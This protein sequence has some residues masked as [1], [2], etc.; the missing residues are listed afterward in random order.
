MLP[1]MVY[2][3]AIT[4]MAALFVW[5]LCK[6]VARASREIDGCRD[7]GHGI[8]YCVLWWGAQGEDD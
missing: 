7:S 5:S 3:F 8:A 2:K 4:A 1:A 6:D